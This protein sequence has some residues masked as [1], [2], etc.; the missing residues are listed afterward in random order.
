MK[1]LTSLKTFVHNHDVSLALTAGAT[2]GVLGM[3]CIY[4]PRNAYLEIT[5]ES[6]AR[7]SQ[8]SV[9]GVYQTRFGTVYTYMKKN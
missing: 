7:M 2:L 5:K 1:A 4:N 3:M 9:G 6:A 8:G